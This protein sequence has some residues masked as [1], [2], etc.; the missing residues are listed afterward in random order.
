MQIAFTY[1]LRNS[2]AEEEAEFD[3]PE[4][5]EAIATALRRAGHDVNLVEVSGPTSNLVARLEEL[6]PDLIFNTAEGSHG[7]FREG[8]YPALFEQLGMPFTGSDAYVCTT[9]LDKRT[10]KMLLD[11]H[12]IPTPRWRFVDKVEQLRGL[13]LRFPVIVKPNFEGSSK[14]ITADSV[15][16]DMEALTAKTSSLL[17]KYPMGILVE[18]YITGRD[19][20]VPFLSGASPE[21]GGILEPAVYNYR[22]E[23]VQDKRFPVYDFAMKSSGFNA[24][25]IQIPADISE[26]TRRNAMKMSDRVFRFLGIRDMGRVDF[27]VTEDG[28]LYFLEVNALP[29]LEPGASIYLA[30]ALAGLER[31]DQVLNTI[32]QSAS[33]RQHN[34]VPYPFVA[35][36]EARARQ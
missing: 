18:E 35:A 26:E 16:E 2:D 1:N 14:G 19:L 17:V 24:V 20:V 23:Y 33:E 30:G 29:S 36:S 5:V 4:T 15:A 21:T 25:S 6:S 8:F 10:T 34:A 9:T 11:A 32:V 28:D 12:G 22:P 27:R 13:S 7:R 31:M 3:L